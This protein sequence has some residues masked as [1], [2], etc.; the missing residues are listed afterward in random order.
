[1]DE[2][3]SILAMPTVIEGVLPPMTAE[4]LELR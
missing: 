1:M 3:D 4:V 2:I